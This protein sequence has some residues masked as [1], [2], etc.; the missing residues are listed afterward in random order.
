MLINPN[1]C[2]SRGQLSFKQTC[3]FITIFPWKQNGKQKS[4]PGP[5]DNAQPIISSMWALHGTLES[6]NF[7]C[8]AQVVKWGVLHPWQNHPGTR[9]SRFAALSVL[10]SLEWEFHGQWIM[11]TSLSKVLNMMVG[12]FLKK[13]QGQLSMRVESVLQ[14]WTQL[15][16]RA[17]KSHALGL[18]YIY[19][20]DRRLI[21]S[22]WQ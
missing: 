18:A 12:I 3:M 2:F 11:K 14:L 9:H 8:G 4:I 20:L 22:V 10:F 17:L 13:R 19:F 7:T 1:Q 6:S 21:L 5:K 16:W 15:L